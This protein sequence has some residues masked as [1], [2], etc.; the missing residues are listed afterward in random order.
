VEAY[1]AVLVNAVDEVRRM[2]CA[3]QRVVLQISA[4]A[5]ITFSVEFFLADENSVSFNVMHAQWNGRKAIQGAGSSCDAYWSFTKRYY[6]VRCVYEDGVLLNPITWFFHSRPRPI[7]HTTN[8][9]VL[10]FC[11]VHR[12]GAYT[13][14]IPVEHCC[15]F[16][17]T[18]MIF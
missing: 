5:N 9:V 10:S 14:V 12:T 13:L 8:D 17:G 6:E 3:G 15:R 11:V 1:V 16:G 7:Q 2:L 18:Q 4:F